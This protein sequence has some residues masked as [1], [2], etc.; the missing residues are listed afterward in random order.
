[1]TGGV[2]VLRLVERRPSAAEPPPA[3][4]RRPETES[5]AAKLVAPGWHG[6]ALC[7]FVPAPG[8]GWNFAVGVTCEACLERLSDTTAAGC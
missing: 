6:G 2:Y 7:G 3:E 1:M 4:R 5:H 8:L